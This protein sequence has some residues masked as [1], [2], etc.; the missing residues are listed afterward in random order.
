M[1]TERRDQIL[2]EIREIKRRLRFVERKAAAL[3][4]T[5]TIS[6]RDAFQRKYPHVR[7]DPKL[8]KLVGIDPP[9]SVQEEKRAIRE[10]IAGWFEAR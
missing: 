9:L 10:T 7:L 3:Q 4:K 8:F 1:K 6:P 2:K 5:R